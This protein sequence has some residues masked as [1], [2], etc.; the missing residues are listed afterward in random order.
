MGPPDVG[1]GGPGKGE[2]P[3]ARASPRPP[4][5]G[6]PGG[7]LVGG[8]A[9]FGLAEN[10]RGGGP[11]PNSPA[12]KSTRE[13]P[14]Q[15]PGGKKAA[16]WNGKIL[17]GSWRRKGGRAAREGSGSPWG[18]FGKGGGPPTG[19]GGRP[20]LR[21]P[22][23]D[24]RQG[25]KVGGKKRRNLLKG[26][27]GEKGPAAE[28]GKKNGEKRE[29]RRTSNRPFHFKKDSKGKGEWGVSPLKRPGKEKGRFG[30]GKLAGGAQK[31]GGGKGA[32]GG[33]P[34]LWPGPPA[35]LGNFWGA[36]EGK[37]K[38]GFFGGLLKKKNFKKFF[39]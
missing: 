25:A 2:G 7:P 1:P 11:G 31:L 21:P 15:R 27:G 20:G 33:R 29:S 32:G 3:S 10:Q 8:G 5:G 28:G 16:P 22:K 12:T 19:G 17:R 38:K 24:S 13:K 23:G 26:F 34:P 4:A 6:A 37:G 39:L 18:A 35:V 14:G 36:G 9:P 30:K